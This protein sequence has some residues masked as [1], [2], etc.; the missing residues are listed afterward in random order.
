LFTSLFPD[1]TLVKCK[2]QPIRLDIE[3]MSARS[4]YTVRNMLH[5]VGELSDVF[6][7]LKWLQFG[8]NVS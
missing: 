1:G 3:K 5:T 8:Q 7:A 4:H 6:R 2:R